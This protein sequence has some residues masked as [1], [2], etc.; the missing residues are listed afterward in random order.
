MVDECVLS[1]VRKDDEGQRVLVPAGHI[2]H[3]LDVDDEQSRYLVGGVVL[4]NG[5]G[6]CAPRAEFACPSISLQRAISSSAFI[7]ERP[8]HSALHGL[9]ALGQTSARRSLCRRHA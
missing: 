1:R 4:L 3:P 7:L 8:L 2:P 6:A 5:T 9:G